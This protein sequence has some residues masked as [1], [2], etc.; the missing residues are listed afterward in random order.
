MTKVCIGRD[1]NRRSISSDG[2]ATGSTEVCAAVT[3]ILYSLAG[4]LTN[5]EADPAEHFVDIQKMEI[6]E[7]HVVMDAFGDCGVEAAFDMAAIG[8][9]QIEKKFPE[10]ICVTLAEA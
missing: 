3:G 6:G 7:A 9:L 8:L 5:A 2:H 1:G 10:F 4:Y